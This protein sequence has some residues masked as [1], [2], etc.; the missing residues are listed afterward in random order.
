ML[1]FTYGRIK[2]MHKPLIGITAGE[3]F[4][5]EHPWA[6]P[7]HGQSHTYVDSIIRSGGIPIIIP[8]TRDVTVLDDICS[9]LD[10][11]LMSGGNDMNPNLYGEKPHAGLDAISDLR[12]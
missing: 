5:R 1:K 10:G 12:D 7:V 11:V 6:P 9:R 4:N 2:R 8:L 3:I